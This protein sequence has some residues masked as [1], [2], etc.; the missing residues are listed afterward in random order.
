MLTVHAEAPG[1]RGGTASVVV[2]WPV[3]PAGELL[4]EAVVAMNVAGPITVYEAV[5]SD[6]SQP[7]PEPTVLSLTGR[8]FVATEPYSAGV[9]PQVV[10]THA[11]DNTVRLAVGFPAEGR[12]ADLV[13]DARS[14]SW[15]RLWWMPSM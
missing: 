11:D 15:P 8:D 14:G 9:A 4:A 5:T 7:L 2:P 3:T 10:Q 13:L 1:W 12:N 6:A